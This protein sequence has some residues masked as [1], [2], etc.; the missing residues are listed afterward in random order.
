MRQTG[1][2]LF[3]GGL[4]LALAGLLFRFPGQSA[5]A[6]RQGVDLCL[7][8]ILPS[9][10]PFFVLSSLFIATGLVGRCAR[11]MEGGMQRLFGVGGAGG[12]VFLLG[13]VGGYPVGA[14]TLAQLVERGDCSRQ[15]AERLSLF[16]NNCGPAFFMGAVGVGIFGS[17]QAGVLLLMSN[18]LAALTLGLLLH[19]LWDR[20][21]APAASRHQSNTIPSFLNTPSSHKATLPAASLPAVLPD[22]V[23]M[24]FS[25]TLGV[26]AYVIL[27]SVLTTLADSTGLLPSEETPLLRCALVGF[28]ELSTGVAHLGEA[29]HVGA[30]LPLAAF[31]LSWGGLSVHCQTLPFWHQAGVSPGPYLLAKF[32]Q[33]L[34]AAGLTAL[35]LHLLPLSL[36]TMATELFSAF[37][38]LWARENLALWTLSGVYFLYTGKRGGNRQEKPL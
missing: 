24:A 6:A 33:G 13:L 3:E 10:F 14:R 16:C 12:S 15:D 25:S 27:F 5:E 20:G 37:P 35:G 28:L 1:R 29:G 7:E 36:P 23:R 18:A 34:L 11:W 17:R 31:L 30:A 19:L 26:C 38:N 8:L 22:C 4:L 32:L 21:K 9:L 2:T